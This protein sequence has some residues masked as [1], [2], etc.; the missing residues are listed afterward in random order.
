MLTADQTKDVNLYNRLMV[1]QAEWA[2]VTE[3]VVLNRWRKSGLF[4]EKRVGE[5]VEVPKQLENHS[6]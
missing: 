3:E 5:D 4:L 2:E 1:L 6:D